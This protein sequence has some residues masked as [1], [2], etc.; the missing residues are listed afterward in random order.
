[1]QAGDGRV[2]RRLVAGGAGADQGALDRR[3]DEAGEGLGVL[4]ADPF[5]AQGGGD[6]RFPALEG[7]GGGGGERRVLGPGQGGG[8]D[9]AAEALRLVLDPAAEHLAE[10]R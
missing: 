10:G 5:L 2:E 9:R 7:R 8:G 6:R 4:F 1:M 3:D